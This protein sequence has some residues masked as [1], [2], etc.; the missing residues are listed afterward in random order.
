MPGQGRPQ[1]PLLRYRAGEVGAFEEIVH[2]YA[3]RLVRFF[4]RLGGDAATAEDLAQEVFLK[5]VRGARAYEPQGRFESFLFRIARNAWI[6]HVRARDARPRPRPI[7][8]GKDREPIP[9][10]DPAPGPVERAG[11]VEDTERMLAALSR[12]PEGERLVVELGLFQGVPYAEVSTI[13]EIPIGTVKSRMFSAV[14][15]LRREMEGIP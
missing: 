12:L 9:V 2:A 5:M 6:D 1:D 8:G 10:P 7:E 4:R 3:D 13:L 11:T 14:R 15:R